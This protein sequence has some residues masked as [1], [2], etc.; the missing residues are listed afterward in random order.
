[1]EI[2]RWAWLMTTILAQTTNPFLL[3]MVGE[4]PIEAIKAEETKK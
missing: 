3:T 1:V 4:S 2:W